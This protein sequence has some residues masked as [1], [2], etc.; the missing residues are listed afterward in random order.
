M[1]E[2]VQLCPCHS[3]ECPQELRLQLYLLQF[4]R[5]AMRLYEDFSVHVGAYDQTRSHGQ[6]PQHSAIQPSVL[7]D[8]VADAY[9]YNTFVDT[10]T[11]T[12][13]TAKSLVGVI[14]ATSVGQEMTTDIQCLLAE[15]EAYSDGLA[16]PFTQ[17]TNRLGHHIALSSMSRNISDSFFNRLLSVLASI[18]LPLSLATSLLSMSTRFIDL[19]PLLYDFCGVV[20]LFASLVILVL[21]LLQKGYQWL[22]WIAK[23]TEFRE[24]VGSHLARSFLS[25]PHNKSALWVCLSVAWLMIM[26]SFLVGMIIDINLGFRILGYGIAGL[27]VFISLVVLS[28][29]IRQVIG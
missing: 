17:L 15:T 3:S 24:T 18:F 2:G 13:T 8:V 11:A 5:T 19:G 26:S 10:A 6:G 20:L 4:Y 12:A 16:S 23:T 27:V 21:L 22:H 1:E 7:A 9:H 25:A 29:A 14:R 28:L